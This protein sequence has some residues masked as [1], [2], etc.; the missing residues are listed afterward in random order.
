V[1]DPAYDLLAAWAL[2]DTSGRE[3]F[4]ASLGVDDATWRRGRGW[5]LSFGAM[6]YPYYRDSNPGL[7]E[8]ARFT[9]VQALADAE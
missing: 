7:V 6:V 4:R 3:R 8:I 1:G 5:A 2:F 9:I